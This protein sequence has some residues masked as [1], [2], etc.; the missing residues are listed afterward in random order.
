MSRRE[1]YSNG[2]FY[3]MILCIGAANGNILRGRELYR[4]RFIDGRPLADQQQLPSYTCFRNLCLR[5]Q[6]TG[7]FQPA[8]REGRPSTRSVDLEEVVIEHFDTNPRTR[9]RRASAILGVNHVQIWRTLREDG[10]HPYHF[11]RTQ[12]LTESDYE[13]RINFCRWNQSRMESDPDFSTRI[14]WTDEASFTR[15]GIANIHN[16]HVWSHLNPH[17]S[18]K[19]SY[20]HQWR[21]NVWAGIINDQVLGPIWLP[22]ALNAQSYLNLLRTE[23]EDQLQEL[24]WLGTIT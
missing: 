5:L 9:T 10:Q 12:E 13:P 1:D 6:S 21:L 18:S 24:S 3:E 20:Q 17:V 11:R 19:S 4:E 15:S 8:T 7:S 2:E 23:V 22:Q 14:L 16:D